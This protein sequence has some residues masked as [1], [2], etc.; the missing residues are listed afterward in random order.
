ME[1]IDN[2]AGTIKTWNNRLPLN[3]GVVLKSPFN[4]I[5]SQVSKRSKKLKRKRNQKKQRRKTRRRNSQTKPA[6]M[7]TIGFGIW[8]VRLGLKWISLH[9]HQ[10]KSGGVAIQDSKNWNPV[11]RGIVGRTSF[12]N[13][14]ERPT[15]GLLSPVGAWVL[16]G[17]KN[18]SKSL[19]HCIMAST[20]T[21]THHRY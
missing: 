2:A 21:M 20:K 18:N 15:W 11:G 6:K 3:T 8:R 9:H 7:L 1:N 13:Q 10:M 19:N 16:K 14:L 17:W 5:A 12:S 4:I